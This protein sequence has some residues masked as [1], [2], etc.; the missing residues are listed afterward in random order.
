MALHEQSCLLRINT[1]GKQERSQ[2]ASL[3]AQIS[4]ILR[5]RDGVQIN[6]ADE[7]RLLTLAGNPLLDRTQIVAD[8]KIT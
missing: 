7:I 5:Y 3:S 6:D 1:T 2:L 8:V 4:R